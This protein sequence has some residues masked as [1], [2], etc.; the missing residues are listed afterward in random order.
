MKEGFRQSMAWLHTWSG[1]LVGWVLFAVFLTGTAAYLKPEIS[2]WM[3]PEL[4]TPAPETPAEQAATAQAL[5]DHMTR[6]APRSPAWFISL[7]EA[8]EPWANVFWRDPGAGGRGFRQ[9]VLDPRSGEPV[10][11]RGTRGGEFFYR[12]HFQLHYMNVPV[13]R[14]IVSFCAMFMLVAIVSGIVTHKRIFAD[15]FTFRPGKGHR[16]W[17]DGHAVAAVLALPYHLMITY[18]GLVTLMFMTMPW[19]G[20]AAYRGDR[21][22]FNTEV[23]GTARPARPA[24]VPAPLVPVGPLLEQASRHWNGGTAGRIQVQ[25][26]GDANSTIQLTRSDSERLSFNPQ[27]MVFSGA[28]GALLSTAGD[29]SRPAAETRGVMYGLHVGRFGGPLLRALFLLSGLAGTAMVATGCVLWAVKTRQQAAKRGRVGFGVRLV[30]HL[31]VAAIAGLPVAMA[32]MFWAN[33]LLPLDLPARD[34][35]EIHGFFIA[36]G[37]CLLHPLLRRGRRAWVEQFAAGALLFGLLP[38]LNALTTTTHLGV[39]LPAGDWGRAG[40]DLGLL[41]IGLALAAIARIVARHRPGA[42]PRAK[43]GAGPGSR[44]GAKPDRASQ[45]ARHGEPVAAE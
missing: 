17:L 10:A 38:L 33:R 9:A 7:P 43:P 45:P 40:F 44:P 13:A 20:E 36:W 16:S 25:N 19:G 22:A 39:T 15:F 23:F 3:M 8:R 27:I 42:A 18:T 41:A 30:E 12:F 14:W 21:A 5:M 6:T 34:E 24:G 4:R 1:L 35:W 29:D 31:N 28:T 11:A 26:P 2:A 37:L 32:T